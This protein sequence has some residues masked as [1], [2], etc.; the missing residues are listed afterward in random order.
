M[1]FIFSLLNPLNAFET[2]PITSYP[3]VGYKEI[4]FFDDSSQQLRKILV[5]YPVES[6]L[7]G[8]PSS[9]LWD[10]FDIAI[11]APIL[12]SQFKKPLI[13]ISHGYGGSPHQLSWLINKFVYN[14]CVVLGIQHI[15]IK[16]D[17]AEIN[18]WKRAQDIHIFLDQFVLQS[19][20]N[21]IDL[22]RIGFAGFSIGGTTG[23]W[24]IGGIST[25]L[26]NFAPSPNDA[27]PEEFEGVEQAL[28]NLDKKK[29]AQDWKD[30]RIK[31]A[32]L[33]S[34]AWG[35][36]FDKKDLKKINIPT[37][38]IAPD[39][40]NVLV[41]ANNAGFFSKNIPKCLYQIIP[42]QVSHYIFISTP[43]DKN[44]LPANLHFLITDAPG[45]DRQWIQFEIAKE[46]FDFFQSVFSNS[47]NQKF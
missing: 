30:S 5:W 26:D 21:F 18:T 7:K 1:L 29:M 43:K 2:H 10:I 38:I 47:P 6:K 9:N 19:F 37:Y 24:A 28:P 35:W 42:G 16:D 39:T 12:K 8:I 32:F 3:V 27:Y 4:P 46:A 15:D 34:P 25:R 13:I 23:I 14:D 31:A 17:K 20:A 36:I 41:T 44:K 22:N 45:I 33:M 40:D 11:D